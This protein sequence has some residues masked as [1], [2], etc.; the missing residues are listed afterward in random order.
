[1]PKKLDSFHEFQQRRA[2]KAR[3]EEGP[4]WADGPSQAG[5]SPRRRYI[6]T[7]DARAIV[8]YVRSEGE[9]AALLKSTITSPER[10][11]LSQ[12]K[13]V[14]KFERQ[15]AEAE[16]LEAAR[17]KRVRFKEEL[18]FPK[19]RN[20]TVTS[21]AQHT[22]YGRRMVPVT[23]YIERMAGNEADLLRTKV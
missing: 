2:G 17:P 9:R 3:P 6:P 23:R 10:Q 22:G 15:K 8:A 12:E 20:T 1:M 14:E 7:T 18:E 13:V 19:P 16:K 21:G 11:Y 4:K 5:P